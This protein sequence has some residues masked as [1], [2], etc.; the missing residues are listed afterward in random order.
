MIR[1]EN[2]LLTRTGPGTPCGELMRR[3]WQPVALSE[4]LPEGSRPLLVK[5]LGEELVLFR[6]RQG[7]PGLL[8]LHCSHRGADLSYGRIEDGGLRCLYHGWM[9]DVSGRVLDMP[10][11]AGGGKPEYR[12][13]IRHLAYPCKEKAGAIFAYMGRGDPA[14]FP[15]YEFLSVPDEQTFAIKLF[16]E[17]NYLQANE[18]N[19][20]L[21]HLSYLHYNRFNRGIGGDLGGPMLPSEERVS[22]RSA[23]GAEECDAELTPHGVRSYKIRRDVGAGKYHLYITEFV[24]PNLTTFP[25]RTRGLV[26]YSVNWHV[27]VDDTR[28]WKYTFQF[29]R[30]A[31]LDKEQE[32]RVRADM[33]PDYRSPTNRNNRYMQDGESMEDSYSGLGKRSDGSYNFQIQDLWATEGQ[34]FIQDRTQEHLAPNDMAVVVSRKVLH[35]AIRD[36]QEGREPNNVKRKPEENLFRLVSVNEM[37]PEEKNWRDRARELEKDVYV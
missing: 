16:H 36:L 2:E 7:C 3:Y 8:G 18:G 9:Y 28:H 14:C 1:E 34:G 20:D 13:S 26:G 12:E 17:C 6:D 30:D 5:I 25:G 29:R 23:V 15:N 10:A 32:R 21:S 19:I 22:D 24:L 11:E 33:T 4:E 31:A 27:P 35:A 37:L